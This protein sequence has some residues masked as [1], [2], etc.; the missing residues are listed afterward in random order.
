MHHLAD[1]VLCTLQENT[2]IFSQLGF[3][4][5]PPAHNTTPTNP[6]TC[7]RQNIL[8]MHIPSLLITQADFSNCDLVSHHLWLLYLSVHHA[9][10]MFLVSSVNNSHN[11]VTLPIHSLL[12][13][14][15][16]LEYYCSLFEQKL[17][18]D[19]FF[20]IKLT[21]FFR[22]PSHYEIFYVTL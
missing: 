18:S 21:P 3:S 9:H 15:S 8:H 16:R 19:T 2:D 20:G 17:M 14:C 5:F 22:C 6:N 11:L 1:I 12:F 7:L 13:L 10:F 4:K